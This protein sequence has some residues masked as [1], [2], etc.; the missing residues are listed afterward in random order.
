[1]NGTKRKK[2]TAKIVI[3]GFVCVDSLDE[4]CSWLASIFISSIELRACHHRL[5]ATQFIVHFHLRTRMVCGFL[6]RWFEQLQR[7]WIC[8]EYFC[9]PLSLFLSYL[10]L[11]YLPLAKCEAEVFIT[12]SLQCILSQSTIRI[13]ISC[14]YS[15][16]C[17]SFTC[18]AGF[19]TFFGFYFYQTFILRLHSKVILMGIECMSRR[20]IIWYQ[21]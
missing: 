1:M 21:F 17:V 18:L 13:T 7:F 14:L 3:Q 20:Q 11:W 15:W 10:W 6:P 12:Y 5:N 19:L 16:P 8:L 2:G 9:F 4:Q